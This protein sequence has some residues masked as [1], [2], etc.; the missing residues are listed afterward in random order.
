MIFSGCQLVLELLLVSILSLMLLSTIFFAMKSSIQ[1]VSCCRRL[2][3]SAVFPPILWGSPV[4]RITVSWPLRVPQL[5]FC[6]L[7]LQ[8]GTFYLREQKREGKWAKIR[9]K[10]P[11]CIFF[12]YWGEG[13]PVRNC[14]GK[15]R[16]ACEA[17]QNLKEDYVLRILNFSWRFENLLI[18]GIFNFENFLT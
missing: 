2:R 10:F 13:S 4:G 14:G 9:A 18:I 6:D 5:P 16:K 7:V 8:Q 17:I 1:Q 15:I 11:F 12:F 3:N